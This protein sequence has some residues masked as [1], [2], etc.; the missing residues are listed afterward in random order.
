[1]TGQKEKKKTLEVERETSMLVSSS[2]SSSMLDTE[3]NPKEKLMGQNDRF[4]LLK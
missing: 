1:M 3:S 4:D 2:S